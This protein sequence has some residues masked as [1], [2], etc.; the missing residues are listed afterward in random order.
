MTDTVD[1]T[2]NAADHYQ[3]G[4]EWLSKAVALY[5]NPKAYD[6][7]WATAAAGIAAAYFAAAGTCVHGLDGSD[8]SPERTSDAAHTPARS[9]RRRRTTT[10][11]LLKEAAEVYRSA[12]EQGHPPTVA[13]AEHFNLSH[14]SAARWVSQA[15]DAGYL[16][17]A[18]GT[19]PG[20]RT[21]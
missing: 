2:L 14:R 9:P 3:E 6:A 20:E 8:A 16:G 4:N 11:A 10:P 19:K 17:L 5:D 18:K 1:A 13:V 12:H 7:G 15:R 21:P